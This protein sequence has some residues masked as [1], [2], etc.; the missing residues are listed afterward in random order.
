MEKDVDLKPWMSISQP[1]P[2]SKE[3]Q[4]ICSKGKM[5]VHVGGIQ[6]SNPPDIGTDMRYTV[7]IDSAK[8]D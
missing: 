1:F 8:T 5:H 6:T 3:N 2:N 4:I 7:F